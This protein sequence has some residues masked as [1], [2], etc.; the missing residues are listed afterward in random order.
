MKEAITGGG[1]LVVDV[2]N[3]IWNLEMIK[4]FGLPENLRGK[5]IKEKQVFLDQ[6]SQKRGKLEIA[7]AELI[8]ERDTYIAEQ[9][10]KQPRKDCDVNS[11]DTVVTETLRD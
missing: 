9:A 8:K 11:F 10:A 3:G 5:S 4:D 1:G 2:K 7:M 6:Q